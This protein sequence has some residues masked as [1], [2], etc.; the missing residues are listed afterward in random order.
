MLWDWFVQKVCYFYNALTHSRLSL[1]DSGCFIFIAS[2]RSAAAK[3]IQLPS[4]MVDI[5]QLVGYRQNVP[6]NSS[7]PFLGS[8]NLRSL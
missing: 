2:M 4:E 5:L 3:M 1:I 6:A 8:K 7:L